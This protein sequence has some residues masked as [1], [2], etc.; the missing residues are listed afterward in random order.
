VGD[1]DFP[2]STTCKLGAPSDDVDLLDAL[3]RLRD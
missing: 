2:T 3:E 1:T